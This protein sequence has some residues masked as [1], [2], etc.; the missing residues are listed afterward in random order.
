[1]IKIIEKGTLQTI[2]CGE[3]GCKFSFEAED[4]HKDVAYNGFPG[5]GAVFKEKKY[6]KCPQCSNLIYISTEKKVGMYEE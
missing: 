4:V 1:M 6:V 2:K 3:C 5:R